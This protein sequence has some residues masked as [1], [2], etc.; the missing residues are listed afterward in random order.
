[1]GH[2]KLFSRVAVLAIVVL[3]FTLFAASSSAANG[4]LKSYIVVMIEEPAVAYEGDV[5]GLPATKPGR[6]GKINPNS[7]HV[8]KYEKFLEERHEQSLEEAGADVS[9]KIHDYTIS[10]NGYSAFLTEAQADAI[11]NQDGVTLV[12]EDEMRQLQTDNSPEFLGLTG[13]AGA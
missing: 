12:M 5:A 8:Q 3:V 6:G 13:P 1:M 11:K 4:E 2:R 7:A 10:L 9:Q